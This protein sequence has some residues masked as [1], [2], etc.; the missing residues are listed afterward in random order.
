MPDMNLLGLRANPEYGVGSPYGPPP[1]GA[2]PIAAAPMAVPQATE[3]TEETAQPVPNVY[4]PTPGT[5]PQGGYPKQ[6]L[7]KGRAPKQ[8]PQR[9]DTEGTPTLTDFI[10]RKYNQDGKHNTVANLTDTDVLALANQF[11]T[12]HYPQAYAA[13]GVKLD[14]KV[15]GAK[16]DS[17]E[18]LVQNN[19]AE[20]R[21]ALLAEEK[22]RMAATG[23]TGAGLTGALGT[24]ALGAVQSGASEALSGL[25]GMA[26][27]VP[28][29]LAG[30]VPGF[31]ET[32]ET[33]F[34]GALDQIGGKIRSGLN[35]LIQPGAASLKQS[36]E[37]NLAANPEVQ[38]EHP[39]LTK[40]AEIAGGIAPYLGASAV[41]GGLGGGAMLGSALF[42][43][44]QMG[45]A[46]HEQ[47]IARINALPEPELQALPEYKTFLKAT[48]GDAD[49]AKTL[50]A[51]A[52]SEAAEEV[53]QILGGIMGSIGGG[54]M[55]QV[56]Q[57]AIAKAIGTGVFRRVLATAG[58]ESAG[59]TG[60]QIASNVLT[61][62]ATNKA[63]GETREPDTLAGTDQAGIMGAVMGA[64]GALL[65]GK[66]KLTKPAPEPT[67]EP[68]AGA[69]PEA[70][71]PGAE[72]PE[73]PPETPPEAP[74]GG[75]PP[76]P[77][78]PP[79]PIPPV[80]DN[81]DAIR[82]VTRLI[83]Q[84]QALA[85]SPDFAED[86]KRGLVGAEQHLKELQ[87]EQT[88]SQVANAEATKAAEVAKAVQEAQA[89]PAPT[90]PAA[91][92]G[93]VTAT[94]AAAAVGTNPLKATGM[95]AKTE[96]IIKLKEMRAKVVE[97]IRLIRKSGEDP[98]RLAHWQEQLAG[99]DKK[100]AEARPGGISD[101]GI[102][103]QMLAELKGLGWTD[104]QIF[105]GMT[106]EEADHHLAHKTGPGGMTSSGAAKTLTETIID[107]QKSRQSL[108]D[109]MAKT[110]PDGRESIK[111]RIDALDKAMDELEKKIQS[112]P[113]VT[114]VPAITE[115]APATPAPVAAPPAPAG[116]NLLKATKPQTRADIEHKLNTWRKM[117]KGAKAA[118]VIQTGKHANASKDGWAASRD[119]L[120]SL[121][122]DIQDYSRMVA[123]YE[124]QLEAAGGPVGE[125]RGELADLK[126]EPTTPMSDHDRITAPD[127]DPRYPLSV[128]RAALDIAK[129]KGKTETPTKAQIEKEAKSI[130]G[131]HGLDIDAAN[132]DRAS[133]EALGTLLEKK[134]GVSPT[135]AEIKAE[136]EDLSDPKSGRSADD[137]YANRAKQRDEHPSVKAKNVLLAKIRKSEAAV[138]QVK[139]KKE[140]EAQKA[141]EAAENARQMQEA[142][143]QQQQQEQQA[144]AAAVTKPAPIPTPIAPAKPAPVTKN[145][146]Q[147]PT[148]TVKPGPTPTV[149][150]SSTETPKPKTPP[151]QAVKTK[152][153]AAPPVKKSP[154]TPTPAKPNV[155]EK[156]A[157]EKPQA[158]KTKPGEKPTVKK[159]PVVPPKRTNVLAKPVPEK[160]QAVKTKPG[161]EH[162]PK[163]PIVPPKAPPPAP[164]AKKE[165]AE[166]AAKSK[167]A[168]PKA[169]FG[170]GDASGESIPQFHSR[171]AKAVDLEF[172]H[173]NLKY[174]PE[175]WKE[176]L[177]DLQAQNKF[178]KAER[179]FM[180]IDLWLD[181]HKGATPTEFKQYIKAHTLRVVS[182]SVK[183]SDWFDEVPKNWTT[184]WSSMD[185]EYITTDPNTGIDWGKG[186]SKIE[187]EKDALRY[188]NSRQP[189]TRYETWTYPDT[190]KL[191]NYREDFI[192]LKPTLHDK[193]EIAEWE[194][195][196]QQH[197]LTERE[198]IRLHVLQERIHTKGEFESPHFPGVK[199][200][201]VHVRAVD[202]LTTEG[203][204]TLFGE[205]VQSEWAKAIFKYKKILREK[206]SD[207]TA[208]LYTPAD[209]KGYSVWD[210][211]GGTRGHTRIVAKSAEQAIDRAARDELVWAEIEPPDMPFKDNRD[212][213]LL[214]IKHLLREA[215]REGHTRVGWTTGETQIR[216]YSLA[217][218]VKQIDVER[219]QKKLAAWER[220]DEDLVNEEEFKIALDIKP[221][222]D[223]PARKQTMKVDL[224]GRIT[225]GYSA[226]EFLHEVVG[227]DVAKQ[228]LAVKN[229]DTFHG[230][231]L[232]RGGEFHKTV[233]DKEGLNAVADYIK[234]WKGKVETKQTRVD[235]AGD[236]DSPGW[237]IR[238]E[239][240][241]K[242]YKV[243]MSDYAGET[244]F[245]NSRVVAKFDTQDEAVAYKRAKE[246]ELAK[247]E[248]IHT[249]K[250]T[251]EMIK[252]IN[253]I[254][255]AHM[256]EGSSLTSKEARESGIRAN[257]PGRVGTRDI[258]FLQ[259]H[260]REG[261]AELGHPNAENARYEQIDYQSLS[262][263]LRTVVAE[264]AKAIG[265]R[266]VVYRNLTPEIENFKGV[267]FGNK[268]LYVNESTRVPATTIA[269]HEFIHQLRVDHPELYNQLAA[270]VRRQG[271]LKAYEGWLT[272]R[273]YKGL[274]EDL[275][276]EELTAN[277]TA[278]AFTDEKF[279]K[280]LAER[281]PS[282]F[283]KI[284]NAFMKFL[285][286]ILGRH[287]DTGSSVY[288]KDVDAFRN[289]LL[290]ILEKYDP[291][292]ASIHREIMDR[293]AEPPGKFARF[294]S[295]KI[296][297]A[298]DALKAAEA[299]SKKPPT[300]ITTARDIL[301]KHPDTLKPTR[302]QKFMH[303]M[304]N[305]L[306]PLQA[307]NEYQER[308]GHTVS[309]AENIFMAF[310]LLRGRQIFE[311][312]AD[313]ANYVN[314]MLDALRVLAQ[315]HNMEDAKFMGLFS[316]WIRAKNA[317]IFNK[318]YELENIKL[319]PEQDEKRIPLKVAHYRGT[320]KGN[321]LEALKEIVDAPGAKMEDSVDP[322]TG[323]TNDE[324]TKIIKAVNKAG[325]SDK[326]GEQFNKSFDPMR[327][328]VTENQLQSGSFSEAD[329][330]RQQA[331]ENPY[332]MPQSDWADEDIRVP[333]K[334]FGS[335]LGAF[336]RLAYLGRE[337]PADDP[338]QAMIN[339]LLFSAKDVADNEATKVVLDAARN[340]NQN[341]RAI[342]RKFDMDQVAEDAIKGGKLLGEMK[343]YAAGPTSI[344]HNEGKYRY[345]ITLP[346]DSQQLRAIKESQ[347]PVPLHG[348]HKAVAVPTGI[349][350]RFHTAL[351][352][353]FALVNAVIRDGLYGPGMMVFQGKSHMIPTYIAN[354][355]KHG[356]PLGAWKAYVT[357]F[358]AATFKEMEDYAKANPNSFAGRLYEL[359]KA[360]GGFNF[361]DEFN[362][363][364][365]LEKLRDMLNAQ[366]TDAKSRAIRA[367]NYFLHLQ[368]AFATGSMMTGRVA[369]FDA[370]IS[371]G[372]SKKEAAFYV[373][374]L[375]D[376]QQTSEGGRILN[377]WFAFAR[378]GLTG[379]DA[380]ISALKDEKG[381]FVPKRAAVG[382][383][384]MGLATATA[385]S[386]IMASMGEDNAK[387]LSDNA[388][389]KN[390]VVPN[391]FDP[392]TPI[393]L[394]IELGMP[395]L[396]WGMSMMA[397]RLATGH[398]NMSSAVRSIKNLLLENVSP[399]HPIEAEEG[400]DSGT[401]AKDLAGA[402]VP[403]TA[404]P[405]YESFINQ[406][407]F[408]SHIH[409][410]PEYTQGYASETA[411][412]T[413]GNMYR[414]IAKFMR[415]N[416]GLDAYPETYKH[417]LSAYDP[418]FMNMLF[419]GLEKSDVQDA[420][421][422]V[423]RSQAGL[424]AA[425]FNHDLEYAAG[426]GY[427]HAKVGLQD[428]RKELDLLESQDKTIPP[429][430]QAK[431]DLDKAFIHASREHSKA[432]RKVTDNKL[433]STGARTSQLA[434][435]QRQW[436]KTQEDLTKK[437][438]QLEH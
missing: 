272:D 226:G 296:S 4:N 336:D 321:Y 207:M 436:S 84:Y 434:A 3:D 413:T 48:G 438:Q 40:G 71:P 243:Y 198:A 196:R 188:Y 384:L 173:K 67:G 200:A 350:G 372:M 66:G 218:V 268:V 388:L 304:V 331:L 145:V 112:R 18:S 126:V 44:A 131:V 291:Q 302:W 333:Q 164:E 194:K 80:V 282:V 323:L 36:G 418:G 47:E 355:M 247:N 255:Q 9:V 244:D 315:K 257:L 280:A 160:P 344:I 235:W 374:R 170:G 45:G 300:L 373:R 324:A 201:A 159:S 176:F 193:T 33:L 414:S 108:V 149:K 224:D 69:E 17:Y 22:K 62:K 310:S 415:E 287:E 334:V 144:A 60:Q 335:P 270:E 220:E 8:Q 395:R 138:D 114:E 313:H 169:K 322:I 400:A 190:G 7:F 153:K 53:N 29:L 411:R 70:V 158:V 12:M 274:N 211:N 128:L 203:E 290:D 106:L 171:L 83:K 129:T 421:L 410:S 130:L 227:E 51:K 399:L 292:Q 148:P 232:R 229:K 30:S 57:A 416:T 354:Y 132:P 119:K 422:E 380:M 86:A 116:N 298:E 293:F 365:K 254:P 73:T 383:G 23:S 277:G 245:G 236:V 343:K 14:D 96:D 206:K 263:E 349:Y 317:L 221:H 100:I 208:K 419:K 19:M 307:Y 406:T 266:I 205:E 93:G 433:M 258:N 346:E 101:T 202:R 424:F 405:L 21:E 288:L 332:Y 251:P 10:M 182:D 77:P 261:L 225:S 143:L 295:E 127:M 163:K 50:L 184:E 161:A 437:A 175:K 24:H 212:W 28:K 353:P 58:V 311:Q 398:T 27:N 133:I 256:A 61:A 368:D 228:I 305:T 431:V 195:L 199:N 20:V 312:N 271:R 326:M 392:N 283:R 316:P 242:P 301:A 113:A 359:E 121:Q 65:H 303:R 390:V 430:I 90:A 191:Q 52:S 141:A 286:T 122:K 123:Q 172:E 157:P 241:E 259:E 38:K 276:V 49:K 85:K 189:H 234:Q 360:G 107:L 239:Y 152:S 435:I 156:P 347:N 2:A 35:P 75:P 269:A 396:A 55:T 197:T 330:R 417:L 214:G 39:Y 248:D 110:T 26:A 318:Q 95:G 210:V 265:H 250:I 150:A 362:N 327:R 397:T 309:T 213:F 89:P 37:E 308:Q 381:K 167:P 299:W 379:V 320:F 147:G 352:P 339:K 342:I 162:K 181:K 230:D 139:A 134:P 165:G 82:S 366:G 364:K 154:V 78:P 329:V 223:A 378:V 74:P 429:A 185:G 385:Y 409:E 1:P 420:G 285:N 425:I 341:L 233:Y 357:H 246:A 249:F 216:R 72:T 238:K 42:G 125:T 278:D 231:N 79:P 279:L 252:A 275:V 187:A 46:S 135:E 284:A 155:L 91:P 68:T 345:I 178:K 180:G 348:I 306:H 219:V 13:R 401:V 356:G 340:P 338:V 393:Q 391:P 94:Q 120:V 217:R 394:P 25:P 314:P 41:T 351:S 59:F 6:M 146:L 325:F 204:K 32:A 264:W 253:S 56:A 43:M 209:A 151:V 281:N 99:L 375:L 358:R 142:M 88:A 11:A 376:Y 98:A 403:S 386:A 361:R 432:V 34:P 92:A 377:S 267:N 186:G 104:Q 105:Q 402:F 137:L 103:K 118:F 117:L 262:P 328:R 16:V 297:T 63:T 31:K 367:K 407:A 64:I 408:G 363:A 76:P 337:T 97:N 168:K 237:S 166:A 426:K 427:H 174:E 222:E 177:D 294:A 124:K 54:G 387:K 382:M 81:S 289:K 412:I 115:E 111:N 371:H 319:T 5:P 192:L 389:S 102:T 369:A 428:A 404:R 179:Q 136:A 370:A 109:A 15:L 87:E 140:L 423:D 183:K 273:N 260:M 240:G 215:V